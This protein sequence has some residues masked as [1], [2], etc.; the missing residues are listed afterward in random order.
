M[1]NN[2]VLLVPG[3]VHDV[4]TVGSS[5]TPVLDRRRLQTTVPPPS[6]A[7]PPPPQQTNWN[8]P[9]PEAFDN[10]CWATRQGGGACIGGL[11]TGLVLTFFFLSL[12]FGG[13]F[14]RRCPSPLRRCP[15]RKAP[16]TDTSGVTVISVDAAAA[17]AAGD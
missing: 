1:L 15:Q 7:S 2:V 10:A 16:S 8:Y 13:V 3:I 11:V 6:L 14:G 4:P 17:P 12:W 5:A 9:D